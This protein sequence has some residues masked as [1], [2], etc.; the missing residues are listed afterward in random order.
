MLLFS[1]LF[2]ISSGGKKFE[3]NFGIGGAGPLTSPWFQPYPL[4]GL[5]AFKRLSRGVLGCARGVG[6]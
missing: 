2:W 3:R 5:N 6:A 4:G 1:S